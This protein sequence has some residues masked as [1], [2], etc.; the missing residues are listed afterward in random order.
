MHIKRLKEI[1]FEFMRLGVLGFGGPIAVIAMM[2]EEFSRKKKWVSREKFLET[3]TLCKV[4]PGPTATQMAIS[5]GRIYEGRL[6]GVLA[7]V[8]FI[9]PAFFLVLG[10]SYFYLQ[11]SVYQK[12]ACFLPGMQVGALAVIFQS[13]LQF[14]R[15]Y[16]RKIKAYGIAG[17]SGLLVLFFPAWEP[18]II[19]GAGLLGVLILKRKKLVLIMMFVFVGATRAFASEFSRVLLP[20]KVLISLFWVCFK[21]GAFVFG[22][23]LAIVPVLEA[24]VVQNF[25][26]L[27][28]SEFMDALAI[29]Q[30]TP[31]PVVIA[32]TFI[33][34]KV[35]G[36]LGACVAT[37][38]I[39]AP[40]FFIILVF[41]PLLKSHFLG[42]KVGSLKQFSEW[43]IPSVIGCILGVSVHL[44]VTTL[45]APSFICLFIL[46]FL[47]GL[48][49]KI[50][51]WAVILGAGVVGAGL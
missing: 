24:D 20:G 26:W 51:S 37:F 16:Q 4:L 18:L 1:V 23:G 3:F 39:F 14:S 49:F 15:P 30:I 5:I 48:F 12:F 42:T 2:E 19:L 45:H 43:A 10:I 35:A 40:C 13:V 34:Y 36:L 46:L 8:S 11:K 29:G 9:L 7:G 31:G 41:I 50:P 44:A 27:T 47:G 22:T 32:A 38:A 17:V 28:H 25:H 21:A 33:G 6:G